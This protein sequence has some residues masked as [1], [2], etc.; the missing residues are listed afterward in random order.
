M[1]LMITMLLGGL[2]HGAAWNFVFWGLLHGIYLAGH[3]LILR[4]NRLGLSLPRMLPGWAGDMLRIFF[5]F[6]LV[7]LTWV[8]FR[9]PDLSSSLLYLKSLFQ[10]DQIPVPSSVVVF[11]GCMMFL[12]DLAQTW[13]GSHTWLSEQHGF[14][15][16]RYSVAQLLLLSVLVAAIGHVQTMTPFIYFQF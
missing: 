11:A 16:L 10:F 1:N 12:L 8:F 7:A 6:H 2:W 5:T 3:R 13:T 14:R 4:D 15:I 9:S